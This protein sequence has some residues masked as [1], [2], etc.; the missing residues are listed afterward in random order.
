MF[1]DRSGSLLKILKMLI[2]NGEK[3]HDDQYLVTDIS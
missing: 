2:E 1:K 3:E